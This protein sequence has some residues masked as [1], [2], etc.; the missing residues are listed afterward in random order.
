MTDF[1]AELTTGE[2]IRMLRERQGKSRAVV[3]GLVGR[4]VEWLKK[5]ETG[6]RELR[7]VTL[8]N[9]LAQVLH[10]DNLSV[11]TGADVSF[12]V[13]DTGK[14]SHPAVP[15]IRDAMHTA[16]FQPAPA[17]VATPEE[18]RGRVEQAWLLWHTDR[19]QRTAVGAILPDLIRTAHATVR[20]VTGVQRRQAQAA[21]GDLYRLV[22]RMLA[23]IC[24]PELYWIALDRARAAGEDADQPLSLALGAWT[25]SIGQRAAGF[26]EEAVRTAELG[27]D[28]IRPLLEDGKPEVVAAYGQLHLQIACSYG[29]DG[30]SG[31]A[32][33]H[34]DEAGRAANRLPAGYW[35]PQ[36][37]FAESN[38]HVHAVS[39]AVGLA[40]PGEALMK[41]DTIDPQT[42][43][44]LERRSRLLLDVAYS[45]HLKKETAAAVH[46]LG[47]A[48]R[49]TP[50]GVRFVP[51]ARALAV[52]LEKTAKGP[53]K[54]SAVALSESLG[55][56]A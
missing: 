52:Q 6:E 5:I 28:V 25:V 41:A 23:H 33:R 37:A 24:E 35:H 54:A 11:L 21:M 15:L 7:N 34:L 46:Y 48:A 10:V 45:H 55:V 27:L 39:I 18:L 26:T 19:H 53:L 20:V 13:T 32:G 14:L 31:P 51:G 17:T 49:L 43:G 56:A 22:Q 50:E 44:S 8:L 40:K 4:S 30:Q 36:S 16:A 29:L 9:K 47:E 3:A 42:I 1:P 38:V 12:P 2:R